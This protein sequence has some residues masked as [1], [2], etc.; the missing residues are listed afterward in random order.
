MAMGF[1]YLCS[2]VGTVAWM[3][4]K[5]HRLRNSR[6]GPPV[7]HAHD[8]HGVGRYRGLT[9]I[10]IRGVT[11]DFLHLEYSGGALYLPVY[12]IGVVHRFVGGSAETGSTP[13]AA[14]CLAT[15]SPRPIYP[16]TQSLIGIIAAD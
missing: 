6:S 11:Q 16:S 14:P 5:P 9:R 4:E 7:F 8:E 13:S 15:P 1:S 10:A 3:L 12:R 2:T